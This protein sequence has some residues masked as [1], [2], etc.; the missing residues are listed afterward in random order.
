MF[1]K[2]ASLKDIPTIETLAWSI[3]P[4]AYKNIISPA[5]IDYMLGLM[6]RSKALQEQMDKGHQFIIAIDDAEKA[7][8]F[9]SFSKKENVANT[10]FRLNKIYVLPN[11]LT[12]RIG[13]A[14]LNFILENIKNKQATILELNVNKQ[15]PAITFY[16]KNG[17]TILKEEIIDIGNDFIM[18]DYVMQKLI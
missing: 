10:I 6:Y 11:Q 18:D 8:G 14:L 1:I 3:W 5:Q 13:T 7:I 15:N 9:A 12:K 4:V 16:K 17:F 2:L